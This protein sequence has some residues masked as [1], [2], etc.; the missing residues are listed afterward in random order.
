[1]VKLLVAIWISSIMRFCGILV[2]TRCNV[3]SDSITPAG[4]DAAGTPA[5]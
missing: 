2:L 1:M 4:V 3:I 5:W